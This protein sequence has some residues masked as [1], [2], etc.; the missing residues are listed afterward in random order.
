RTAEAW[1]LADQPRRMRTAAEF[2][3]GAIRRAE[4]FAAAGE[5]TEESIGELAAAQAEVADL[6]RHTRFL[7]EIEQIN[8]DHLSQQ[9]G[10]FDYY[11]R[12]RRLTAA[13]RDFGL[14]VMG[15]PP[16]SVATT[17]VASRVREK[18][19]GFLFEWHFGA[20]DAVQR[21][22]VKAVLQ[23]ATRLADGVVGRVL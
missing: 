18:L 17:V 23:S 19:L 6:L 21:E 8:N 10:G 9:T 22:R 16:E 3:D 11:L 12:A 1:G 20:P 2:A 7:G 14:D 5:T 4:G 13:F 15:D